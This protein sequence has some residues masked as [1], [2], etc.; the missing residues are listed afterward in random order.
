[1]WIAWWVGVGGKESHAPEGCT[2]LFGRI[3]SGARGKQ[4]ATAAVCGGGVGEEEEEWAQRE[5]ERP[6]GAAQTGRSDPH[7]LSIHTH[8]A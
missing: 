8:T 4:A 1:M 2:C 3:C 5:V 7:S 6:W